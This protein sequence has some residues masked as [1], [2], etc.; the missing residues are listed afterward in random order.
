MQQTVDDSRELS[1]QLR[2]L[3][4]DDSADCVRETVDDETFGT[5]DAATG[6]L[7]YVSIGNDNYHNIDLPLDPAT[8]KK[9]PIR[10]LYVH[11]GDVWNV[12]EDDLSKIVISSAT[13][14]TSLYYCPNDTKGGVMI[15]PWYHKDQRDDAMTFPV[16]TSATM[17][18]CGLATFCRCWIAPELKG[19]EIAFQ[20]QTELD[21][22][23]IFN[24]LK[25]LYPKLE[26]LRTFVKQSGETIREFKL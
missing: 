1:S 7:S 20:K 24:E 25:V 3:M 14:L 13:T 11:N 6:K 2:A 12:A 23:S 8:G 18:S 26:T 21:V 15:R 19:I 9:V 22:E 10:E 16:L 4:R 17:N 5:I